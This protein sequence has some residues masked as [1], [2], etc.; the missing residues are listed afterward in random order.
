MNDQIR[1]RIIKPEDIPLVGSLIRNTIKTSYTAVYPPRAI[2]FFLKYHTDESILRRQESGIVIVAE[3]G[4]E[5]VAT[6]S[7]VGKEITGVF[8][9]SHLQ[10]NNIGSLVMDR[11]ETLA[12]ENGYDH[13]E[14]SISLPSWGFYEKRGYNII[15]SANIDVG[16]AQ[17][18]E[19][20]EGVKVLNKK[21]EGTLHH[22][23]LV[24]TAPLVP[25]GISAAGDCAVV[26]SHDPEE[27]EALDNLLWEVLWQPLGLPR[28]IRQ[29]FHIE[30]TLRQFIVCPHRVVVAG[31]V[32]RATGTT[33][34]EIC[35]VAVRP[36]T[37]R[38]GIGRGLVEHIIDTARKELYS[39]IRVITRNTSEKF[40]RNFG[41][42][43]LP[44]AFPDHPAFKKYGISFRV[45]EMLLKTA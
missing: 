31:A 20:W 44:Q 32:V 35:H 6:G 43:A 40:F 9:K 23:P 7:L 45:M 38:K 21:T 30:G 28:D 12:A 17:V 25:S 3:R 36:G 37:Q 10:D 13:V 22:D 15:K 1:L 14:L 4:E 26:E 29:S 33:E 5:I 42:E 39:R 41:F 8:V 19:Y 18:L 16:M 11:L 24:H 34:M 2:E 27:I